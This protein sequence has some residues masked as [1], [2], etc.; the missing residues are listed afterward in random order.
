[1]PFDRKRYRETKKWMLESLSIKQWCMPENWTLSDQIKAY[2]P[3]IVDCAHR[4]DYEGAQ[5]TKDAIVE[6]LNKFLPESERL[7]GFEKLNLP[8]YEPLEIHG[9]I[10]F[11]E[12][13]SRGNDTGKSAAITI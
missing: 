2:L 1:M 13:D 7:T 5:A 8:D 11:V 3:L 6:F 10:C 4:E 9:I 12:T